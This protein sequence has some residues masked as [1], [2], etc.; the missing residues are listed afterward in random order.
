MRLTED[1]VMISGSI[2]VVVVVVLV[3]AGALV[4]L[5][6]TFENLDKEKYLLGFLWWLEMKDWDCKLDGNNLVWR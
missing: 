1:P 4:S 3:V 5:R 2:R 6:K